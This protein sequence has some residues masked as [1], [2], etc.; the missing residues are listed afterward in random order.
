MS[1]TY[2]MRKTLEFNKPAIKMA[3]YHGRNEKAVEIAKNAKNMGIEISVISKLAG[4]S[5][6]EIESL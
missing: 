3:G 6:S 2:G 1:H 5:V 4:L